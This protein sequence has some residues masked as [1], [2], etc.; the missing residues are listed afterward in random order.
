VFLTWFAR[1]LPLTHA[2]AIV[3][4]GLL[5]DPSGPVGSGTCTAQPGWPG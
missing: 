5:D 3:R 4:Y 2:L 1:F